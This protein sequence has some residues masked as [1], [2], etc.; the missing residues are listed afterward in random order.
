MLGDWNI[1]QPTMR[2]VIWG[3]SGA[4]ETYG[5]PLES[6]LL[7]KHYLYFPLMVLGAPLFWYALLL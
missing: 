6:M 4:T 7:S 1:L 3:F 2:M 5:R